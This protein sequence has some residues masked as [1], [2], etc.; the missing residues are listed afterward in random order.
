MVRLPDCRQV[1]SVRL[2]K[3]DR[4]LVR[5]A[6]AA[7]DLIHKQVDV[8]QYV[9]LS[10]PARLAGMQENSSGEAVEGQ[11]VERSGY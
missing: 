7:Y 11:Q 8:C 1:V 3:E 10:R 9:L 5:V 4:L 6:R 2:L